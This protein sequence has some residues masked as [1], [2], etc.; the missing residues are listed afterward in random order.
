MK[1][2]RRNR[3]NTETRFPTAV[4]DRW[5]P[6][7]NTRAATFADRRAVASKRACRGKVAWD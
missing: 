2:N 7:D 6:N 3:R 1:S 4:K 5:L